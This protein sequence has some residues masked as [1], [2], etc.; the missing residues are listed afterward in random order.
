MPS[1]PRVLAR[2]SCAAVLLLA[3][4]AAGRPAQP[5]VVE[6]PSEPTCRR[7]EIVL[8]RVAVLRG[9]PDTVSLD[10]GIFVAQDRRGRFFVTPGFPRYYAVVYGPDGR[11]LRTLGRDGEGP[12]EIRYAQYILPGPGDSISMFDPLLRRMTV[13]SPELQPARTS[14]SDLWVIGDALRLPG[15]RILAQSRI[16]SRDRAGYPLHAATPDWRVV[17]SFGSDGS[18]HP[19]RYMDQVRALGASTPSRVWV[20][21][22]NRYQVE[23]W[24][25]NGN[26]LKTLTRQ[27]AWFAPW[28]Q[29]NRP[30][31][32]EPPEPL[33]RSVR[34]DATGHLWVFINVPDAR[35]KPGRRALSGR[36]EMEVVARVREDAYFDTMIEVLDPVRGRV[37]TRSRSG[38]KLGSLAAGSPYLYSTRS[39]ASGAELID[40]WLPVLDHPSDRR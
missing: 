18:L 4:Q 34:Q 28:Q 37:V 2:A 38:R 21:W 16:P 5:P 1:L 26:H 15:G 14:L 35:W 19:D 40:V 32:V 30:A 11:F 17:T 36:R 25:V 13:F 27:P 6:I 23:L 29:S 3:L 20:A 8:R 10:Y 9:L 33:L 31:D 24:T 7:C 22:R 12:G 39:D